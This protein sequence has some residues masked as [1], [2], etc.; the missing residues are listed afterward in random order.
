MLSGGQASSDSLRK[1]NP[2]LVKTALGR[3]LMEVGVSSSLSFL[4]GMVSGHL[5][6]LPE[7]ILVPNQDYTRSNC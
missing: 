1:D 2:H 6:L 3:D 4:A 7:I 5:S